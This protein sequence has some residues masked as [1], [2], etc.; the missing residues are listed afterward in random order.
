MKPMSSWILIELITAESQWELHVYIF[1]GHVP[2]FLGPGMETSHSSYNV[3]SLTLWATRELETL[4]ILKIEHLSRDWLT[5]ESKEIWTKDWDVW[6]VEVPW[7]PGG[8][9]QGVPGVGGL[10]M[11]CLDLTIKAVLALVAPAAPSHGPFWCQC[12]KKEIQEVQKNKNIFERASKKF[13]LWLSA[14]GPD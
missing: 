11:K 12:S 13:T 8:N 9:K 5:A 14:N 2:V 6:G 3:G 1:F 7:R 10:P 4:H